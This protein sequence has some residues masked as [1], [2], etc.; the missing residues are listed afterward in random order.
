M[1]EEN[2]TGGN[3]PV[4]TISLETAQEWVKNWRSNPDNSVRS[5]LIPRIDMTQLLENKDTVDIRAYCGTDSE[6]LDKLMFVGIDAKGNDLID[7]SK[8]YYI[9]DLTVPCPPKCPPTSLLNNF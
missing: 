5:H 2:I 9:Y 1:S 6:G 3:D 7:E 8:G 4:N